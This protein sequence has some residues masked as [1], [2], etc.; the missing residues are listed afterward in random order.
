[1]ERLVE[2]FS[3]RIRDAHCSRLTLPNVP[4]GSPNC[5]VIV[6]SCPAKRFDFAHPETKSGRMFSIRI[7][8]AQVLPFRGDMLCDNGFKCSVI[9]QARV[10]DA[11][12]CPDT[13]GFYVQ[14]GKTSLQHAFRPKG[15]ALCQPGASPQERNTSELLSPKGAALRRISS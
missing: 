2:R 5:L 3:D 10:N 11:F 14:S 12:E 7:T 1:M 8:K 4:I 9:T 15:P 13:T 6:F